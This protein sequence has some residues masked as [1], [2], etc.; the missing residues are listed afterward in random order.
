MKQ[1]TQPIEKAVASD[2]NVLSL[3]SIFY[4]IQGEGP[5]TG[6]PAVF[7]RLAGCNLQ[8]PGCDTDY[9]EG[10]KD[11]TIQ[12]ILKLVAHVRQDA[13]WQ[14]HSSRPLVVITGG[15]PFRQNILPLCL[16]L[17]A[18]GYTIQIETNGTLPPPKNF[19]AEIMIVCSP[20]AG[21]INSVMEN[22]V[23][24]Y[25]YVLSRGSMACDGLPTLV[26]GHGA[27]PHVAR[28]SEKYRKPIYLQ[29]MDSQDEAENKKNLDTVITSCMAN[30]YIL[31][32]QLHKLINME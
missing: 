26:L 6:V 15:E 22:R 10:R 28:P 9:T 1:N 17:L 30:G 18:N 8:C 14:V 3:H 24:C 21:K 20:K 23:D 16:L 12:G 32:L 13:T 29:P 27:Y 19:P 2:G 25:K 31:Q 5:Y 7:I 4:T 11:A